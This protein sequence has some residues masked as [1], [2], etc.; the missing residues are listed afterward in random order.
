M[1]TFIRLVG[2]TGA[3]LCAALLAI[4]ITSPKSFER[5][6]VGFAKQQVEA[7][8]SARYPGLGNN[9]LVDGARQLS[10]VF[11]NRKSNTEAVEISNLPEMVARVV[12]Q[13]CGC[14]DPISIS[15]RADTI[16]AALKARIAR[17]GLAE[18]N[19]AD[20]IKGKYDQIVSALKSDLTI[21]LV[22]NLAAFAGVFAVSFAPRERRGLVVIPGVLMLIAASVASY[23]YL[24]E[25]DWFYAIIF[26]QYY[27]WGYAV[28]MLVIFG[29]LMDIVLN[30]ARFCLNIASNLPSA[31]I[32]QC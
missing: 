16:R 10:K 32:P 29:L 14:T 30:Q 18:A 4:V 23:V 5:T 21:F 28:G 12:S 8:I 13:H 11:A 24:A 31:M 22:T 20:I 7:E 15:A 25:Q 3:L 27:G 1:L 26:Q 17:L 2:I 19:L 6:A 9:R